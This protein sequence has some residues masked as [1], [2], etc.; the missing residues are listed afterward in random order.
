MKPW[1]QY[2]IMENTKRLELFYDFR[3]FLDELPDERKNWASMQRYPVLIH[4][5]KTSGCIGGWVSVFF[6][7]GCTCLDEYVTE[8]FDITDEESQFICYG[9]HWNLYDESD[10]LDLGNWDEAMRRFNKVIAHYEF[11][12]GKAPRTYLITNT[13]FIRI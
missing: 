3:K 4:D 11:L 13:H 1:K 12:E 8:A 6:Q 9:E 2:I 7:M 5:G 10:I